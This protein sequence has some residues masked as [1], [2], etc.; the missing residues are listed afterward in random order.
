MQSDPIGLAGGLNTYGYAYQS[1]LVYSDPEGLNPGGLAGAGI[2]SFGG[3]V[4][5][6]AGYAI[7]TVVFVGGIAWNQYEAQKRGLPGEGDDGASESSKDKSSKCA[8]RCKHHLEDNPHRP[9]NKRRPKRRRGGAPSDK[10]TNNYLKCY[11]ECMED[12]ECEK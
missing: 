4:G 9:P 7:G 6:A 10:Y 2:G 8:E 5:A 3:P 1:P 11:N 12:D